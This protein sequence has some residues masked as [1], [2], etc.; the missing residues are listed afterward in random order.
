MKMVNE[1]PLGRPTRT[2]PR[3]YKKGIQNKER[4]DTSKAVLIMRGK[5]KTRE[6]LVIS[7]S[8]S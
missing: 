4:V 5:R 8:H 6:S 7:E 2:R 1:N 3:D